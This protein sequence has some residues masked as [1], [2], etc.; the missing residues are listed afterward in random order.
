MRQKLI[1]I[2]SRDNAAV[3]LDALSPGEEAVLAG[4]TYQVREDIPFGH[5]MALEDLASGAVVVK[6]GC[7][8]GHVTRAVKAGGELSARRHKAAQELAKRIQSELTQL[9]MPKVRFQVE[10]APKDAPDG[11]DATGMDTVR[12]LMSANVGEALKPINKIASGGELSR[13]MLAL[14]NVLAETEQVSTLIFDEVDTGV[15]GRAAVKVARK[16]FEVSKGRQVLCV[17]HLPQIAA[18]GDVHF[19]VEKGEADGRTFTRVE[20]L[21]RPRRREELARL[22]GGQATA[23]MLEGAE[24]LLATAQDY[25]TGAKKKR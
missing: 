20:R 8:I 23:V 9:D 3:A 5:K 15:S 13:I 4:R 14:K 17:T 6:Y 2:D 21:D 10:F 11:M 16:L 24:E 12:F 25:K 1:Q 19:S 22:S 7:P 18:M